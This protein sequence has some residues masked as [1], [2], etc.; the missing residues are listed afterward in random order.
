MIVVLLAQCRNPAQNI[1][2]LSGR[3][4]PKHRPSLPTNLEV[5]D[6]RRVPCA[7][8]EVRD[9]GCRRSAEGRALTK[10]IGTVQT[11]YSARSLHL[12]LPSL[13]EPL[14]SRT[15]V[16]RASP[17]GHVIGVRGDFQRVVRPVTPIP[18]PR[19]CM[20]VILVKIGEP[21][22]RLPI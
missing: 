11:Y 14:A 9:G 1:E 6:K 22:D 16:C 21:G 20:G 17:E 12:P 5:Q 18:G 7:L 10:S 8:P 15:C 3:K 19:A 4:S 13:T 2:L